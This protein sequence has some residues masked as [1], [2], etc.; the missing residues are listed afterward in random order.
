MNLCGWW[1]VSGIL[2]VSGGDV[3]GDGTEISMY[4]MSEIVNKQEISA[5]ISN[6][7]LNISLMKLSNIIWRKH[8]KI[9]FKKMMP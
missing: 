7:K 1:A 6:I 8:F 3:G 9:V 5:T 4:H 2:I